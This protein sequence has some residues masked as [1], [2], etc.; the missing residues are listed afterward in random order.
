MPHLGGADPDPNMHWDYK[1]QLSQADMAGGGTAYYVYDSAGQRV[2]KV[3]E[4]APGLTEEHIYVGSFEVFRRINGKGQFMLQ[5]ETLHIMDDKQRI[6]LVETRTPGIGPPDPAPGQLIRYQLGNHLGSASLE[7]DD[8]AQIISYEEYTPYG[9]TSYQAMRSTT[10]TPKRYRY[11]GKERDEESGLYYH[12][13]RYYAP[14]LGRWMSCDPLSRDGLN[15]YS[16]VQDSPTTQLDS[17]GMYEEPGHFYTVFAMALASGMAPNTAR[18]IA[19]FSQAPDEIQELDAIGT[20]VIYANRLTQASNKKQAGV[21]E[22]AAERAALEEAAA[23]AE[24]VHV[25]IHALSG[26][27][28]EGERAKRASILL[29]LKP[30]TPEY[31]A[32][33]HAFGDSFAHTEPL[34]RNIP[35]IPGPEMSPFLAQHQFGGEGDFPTGHG[36]AG[37]TPDQIDWRP[38]LYARYGMSLYGIFRAQAPAVAI[39][40]T[41][42]DVVDLLK[43]VGTLKSPADQIKLLK[44]FISAHGGNLDYEPEAIKT[45]SFSAAITTKGNPAEF[46]EINVGRLVNIAA[47]WEGTAAPDRTLEQIISGPTSP[48]PGTPPTWRH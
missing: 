33:V 48:L 23:R 42:K 11:T 24:F 41:P 10:E 39:A 3:W 38:Q 8:H 30:G 44:E 6:A 19:V 31:G 46:R 34:S 32:A 28:A 14:W 18:R 21:A 27:P 37:T 12:G 15:R 20:T 29:G 1:D 13:A 17:T 47:T 36:R 43:K 25:G 16:Y 40:S 2:R 4:K 45:K 35:D 5:R 9:S 7:L 26:A 22:T